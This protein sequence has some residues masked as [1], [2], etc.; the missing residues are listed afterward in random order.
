[1]RDIEFQ[2]KFVLGMK[3][4]IIFFSIQIFNKRQ[5]LKKKKVPTFTYS[6]MASIQIMVWDM[7]N[8]DLR[9]CII[10]TIYKTKTSKQRVHEQCF[11]P[12]LF[13]SPQ[14]CEVG[15][16]VIIHKR[17]WPNLGTRKVE[18]C[19]IPLTCWNL[20]SKYGDFRKKFLIM[21]WHIMMTWAHSPPLPPKSPLYH[22]HLHFFFGH[23]Q[24]TKIH[25]LQNKKEHHSWVTK[26]S[27]CII[28]IIIFMMICLITFGRE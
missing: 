23:H 21:W 5:N 27:M 10:F 16:L 14:I 3:I 25:W 19:R 13:C 20:L 1:M 8:G 17:T 4:F 7:T 18:K 9:H 11:F 28:I 6:R 15:G 26:L 12:F 22:L 2:Q 24:Y